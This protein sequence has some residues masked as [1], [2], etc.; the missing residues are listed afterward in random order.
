MTRRLVVTLRAKQ[1]MQRIDSWW[2]HN[3]Q[4]S[5]DLFY[6]ELQDAFDLIRRRPTIGQ[7]YASRSGKARRVL[8]RGTRYHVY[9]KVTPTQISVVT[10]WSAVRGRGPKL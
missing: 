3:R 6:L 8:L 7:R 5:A 10:I 4:L 1:D 9:Y 2:V